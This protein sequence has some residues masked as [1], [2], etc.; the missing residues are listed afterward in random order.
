MAPKIGPL[1]LIYRSKICKGHLCFVMFI[2]AGCLFPH[3]ACALLL[4]STANNFK[5]CIRKFTVGLV[6][7]LMIS[8]MKFNNLHVHCTRNVECIFQI[9][10]KIA[11]INYKL[12]Y[13]HFPIV[14]CLIQL[15]IKEGFYIRRH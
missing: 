1:F 7:I 8:S 13:L 6:K 15:R 4:V 9:R 2:F 12:T 3:D 11:R 5:F 10:I 14:R